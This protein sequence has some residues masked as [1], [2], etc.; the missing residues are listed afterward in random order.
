M[1]FSWNPQ[2]M[3]RVFVLPASVAQQHIRLAGPVQ[4]K[5]LLWL[6]AEGTGVFDAQACARAIGRPAADCTDAL[7]YWIETGVLCPA[8]AAPAQPAGTALPA[9]VPEE[10]GSAAAP[11]RAVPRAVKPQMEEVLRRQK[12]CGELGYLFDAMSARLGKPLSPGDMETLTY[13]F[14]TVRLPAAVILMVAGYAAEQDK[15]SMR[16]IEK[17]ALG[18]ADQGLTTV[19]AAEQ[20]LCRQKKLHRY[21]DQIRQLLNLPASPT[22]AQAA[23]ATVWLDEWKM[24]EELILLAHRQSIEKTGKCHFGYMH[25]A[26]EHWHADGITDPAQI[27]DVPAAGKKKPS[28]RGSSMNLDQYEQ[29]LL[30]RVPVYKKRK[31]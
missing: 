11:P 5:V 21:A 1:Q 18:W 29:T 26:L 22:A 6:A 14:D 13:L 20:Y 30:K 25:K 23:Q 31:A 15:L 27:S 8:D 12:E 7:Q 16:Y 17:V 4:L 2:Q 24:S 10:E 9:A 19:D 28:G 3:N